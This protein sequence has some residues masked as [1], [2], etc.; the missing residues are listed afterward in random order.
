MTD[1]VIK[2]DGTELKT[3]SKN[4]ADVFDNPHRT[5]LNDIKKLKCSDEFRE[6]HFMLSSYISNQNKEL[7]C[8]EMTDK[9]FYFLALGYTGDKAAKFK[10]AYINEFDRMAKE[11]NSYSAQID[12]LSIEGRKIKELGSEWAGFGHRIRKAKSEHKQAVK[13]LMSDVQLKIDI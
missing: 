9:G 10:E 11:Q 8:V 3:N 5:V 6:Q 13:L 7:P 1:I 12:N 4:V 2:K